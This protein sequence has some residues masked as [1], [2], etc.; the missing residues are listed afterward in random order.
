MNLSKKTKA[1]LIA[2]IDGYEEGRADTLA[3]IDPE[4]I[5]LSKIYDALFEMVGDRHWYNYPRVPHS[6][7]ASS[8]TD[9]PRRSWL[10]GSV[11]RILTTAG[12][13]FG[14]EL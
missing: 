10:R 14:V 3:D 9:N 5:A 11:T 6:K 7:E 8:D 13:R 1:E 12:Q 2:I 4:A